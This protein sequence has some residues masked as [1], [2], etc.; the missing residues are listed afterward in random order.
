MKKLTK[1]KLTN[2]MLTKKFANPMETIGTRSQ[3]KSLNKWKSD[4][5][6]SQIS[7]ATSSGSLAM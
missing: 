7:A 5:H 1:K 3:V 6:S 4:K 2:K